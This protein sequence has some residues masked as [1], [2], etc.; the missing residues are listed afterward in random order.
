MA[1]L[2]TVMIA[3]CTLPI[4]ASAQV[5]YILRP[6]EYADG[7][8]RPKGEDFDWV[9]SVDN[10][11]TVPAG[12]QKLS[13]PDYA[14]GE[15]KAFLVGTPT[16]KSCFYATFNAKIT[17]NG[18][19]NVTFKADWYTQTLVDRNTGKDYRTD[20]TIL[21][22]DVYY[23]WTTKDSLFVSDPDTDMINLYMFAS[24]DLIKEFLIVNMYQDGNR[25]C[26]LGVFSDSNQKP[27]GNIFMTRFAGTVEVKPNELDGF[28]PI[29]TEVDA[30]AYFTDI[31]DWKKGMI[32]SYGITPQVDFTLDRNGNWTVSIGRLQYFDD[33]LGR[34]F[35]VE[36]LVVR[37]TASDETTK[38]NIKIDRYSFPEEY[39]EFGIDGE[40]ALC[41]RVTSVD[42]ILS[43][44]YYSDNGKEA[45]GEA[46]CACDVS[47]IYTGL[48]AIPDFSVQDKTKINFY[49]TLTGPLTNS[50]YS[51]GE[52][53]GISG[54]G[55]ASSTTVV[56]FSIELDMPLSQFRWISTK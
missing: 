2:L 31:C 24:A 35:E 14:E 4:A 10:I 40:Q 47:S 51:D 39:T 50:A 15:W 46:F 19:N 1:G 8:D 36:G 48:K 11:F 20:T 16:D 56:N 17:D 55:W 52:L 29:D 54:E 42:Q 34:S 26:A 3:V 21:P 27:L 18:N 53:I 45:V 28:I 33:Y 23:G 9:R 38:E 32:Q 37:G 7:A 43:R 25:Q 5:Q 12:A 49:L 41:S 6:S 22:D 13:I 44:E 30:T